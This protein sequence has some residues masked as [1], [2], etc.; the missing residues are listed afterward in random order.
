MSTDRGLR[1]LNATPETVSGA[2][3]QQC[4]I[5][6]M[7]STPAEPGIR[8][9]SVQVLQNVLSE[10]HSKCI[11]LS[12]D[13]HGRAQILYSMTADQ[14]I[15]M[16]AH[17]KQEPINKE[18]S[19]QIMKAAKA[20]SW[21]Y[22]REECK[23]LRRQ[24]GELKATGRRATK[25]AEEL[26]NQIVQ[27][28]N[29]KTELIAKHEMILWIKNAQLEKSRE[30]TAKFEKQQRTD[31]HESAVRKGLSDINDIRKKHE[32]TL[33][34]MDFELQQAKT[35]IDTLKKQRQWDA[36]SH[37]SSLAEV[38]LDRD[39]IRRKHAEDLQ[40]KN[41]DLRRANVEMEALRK[42]LS[43]SIDSN[44]STET[45]GPR[46]LSEENN[47]MKENPKITDTPP[48][49]LIH[50][51]LYVAAPEIRREVIYFDA[52]AKKAEIARRPSR[53]QTFG[54]VLANV[55]KERG[56]YPHRERNRHLTEE[57][58]KPS[59]GSPHG[60]KASLVEVDGALRAVPGRAESKNDEEPE[61]GEVEVLCG[62]DLAQKRFRDITWIPK[63][64][65]P[66]L[67]DNQLAY[68]DG[69]RVPDVPLSATAHDTNW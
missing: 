20:S 5:K 13:S 2:H 14:E 45:S 33:R 25:A 48:P 38:I 49:T 39:A 12:N 64:A 7:N 8:Q 68:R 43:A 21:S 17:L 4:S 46:G 52:E 34:S 69:T 51:N 9:H 15:H 61:S 66:C 57:S 41:E 65:I 19:M 56:L 23:L 18:S 67:V 30:A 50:R 44:L 62:N 37:G 3:I 26:R 59:K 1:A 10:A 54:H 60:N 55:R 36:H 42:Q 31:K 40:T 47:V 22:S 63:N 32:E 29:E 24:L 11:P 27:L 35:E 6:C 28:T 16:S 58:E 53:K